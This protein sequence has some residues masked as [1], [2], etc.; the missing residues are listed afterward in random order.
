MATI[1]QSAIGLEMS[2]G[3]TTTVLLARDGLP[4]PAILLAKV[5]GDNG[6][7]AVFSVQASPDEGETWYDLKIV[8]LTGADE[9]ALSASVTFGAAGARAVADIPYTLPDWQV[10]VSVAVTTHPITVDMW[11]EG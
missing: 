6:F 4:C 9:D 1:H 2:V 10:R 5:A 7:G 3:E 11:L 8:D